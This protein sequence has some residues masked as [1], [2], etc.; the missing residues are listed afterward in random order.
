MFLIV[1]GIKL[2]FGELAPWHSLCGGLRFLTVLGPL[3]I[4]ERYFRLSP[5]G[6][7][8]SRSN[9]Y[10]T[11]AAATM[12]QCEAQ[13]L[14]YLFHSETNSTSAPSEMPNEATSRSPVPG[15]QDNEVS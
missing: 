9:I 12:Q 15:S 2:W 11:Q 6:L 7:A 1:L 4:N 10:P 3:I 13:M 5:E 14:W 8:S